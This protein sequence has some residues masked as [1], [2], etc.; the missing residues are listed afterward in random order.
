MQG[1][2][3]RIPIL[4]LSGSWQVALQMQKQ[5]SYMKSSES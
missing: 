1:L 4:Q 3:K 2:M 5:K